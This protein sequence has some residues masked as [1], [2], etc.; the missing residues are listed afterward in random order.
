MPQFQLPRLNRPFLGR[1]PECRRILAA[2][3]RRRLVTLL[4]P[5]GMGKTS[6]AL[7]VAHALR[8]RG[9]PRDGILFVSLRGARSLEAVLFALGRAAGALGSGPRPVLQALRGRRA[10]LVLDN[11]EDPLAVAR[12][13]LQELAAEILRRGKGLRLLLTSSRRLGPVLGGGLVEEVLS[14]GPLPEPA[15]ERLLAR[16][17]GTSPQE[18]ASASASNLIKGLGGHPLAI[19][20]AAPLLARRGPAELASRL[21]DQP[22]DADPRAGTPEPERRAIEA[23]SAAAALAV[24]ELKESRPDAAR[25]LGLLTRLPG[26]ALAEDLDAAAGEGWREPMSALLRSGLV[27]RAELADTGQYTVPLFLLARAARML[28]ESGPM[29]PRAGRHYAAMGRTL[30]RA[31]GAGGKEA[32]AALSLLAVEELNLWAA[33]DPSRGAAG[34]DGL[35]LAACLP[36]ILLRAGRPR[37]ALRAAELGAAALREGSDVHAAERVLQQLVELKLRAG[38]LA[39]A[40]AAGERLVDA[41]RRSGNERTEANALRVL[42]DLKLR[43]KDLGAALRDYELALALHREIGNAAGEANCREGLGRLRLVEENPEAARREFGAALAIHLERG[44][45]QGISANIGYLGRA[46]SAAGRHAAAAVL[47]DEALKLH[48][49]AGDRSGEALDLQSQAEALWALGSRPGALAAWWQA[50]ALFRG[51]HRASAKEIE[52]V[53]AD[54]HARLGEAAYRELLQDLERNAETRRKASVEALRG[55]ALAD[56]FLEGILRSLQP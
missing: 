36:G 10:L 7:A 20:L 31:L 40:R 54:L 44:E 2:L 35:E 4:G 39:S 6:V 28:G 5:A 37:D 45:A 22:V 29:S 18:P 38:D 3:G 41:A 24:A 50:H 25:L 12:D 49:R 42:G 43:Q 26:G 9:R 47:F 52:K 34:D 16:L 8:R 21:R 48:R 27:S 23:L 11:C 14:L 46:E 15:A 19:R 17:S 51:L 1:T 53:F 32:S 56:P 33:L 13:E 30:L 55:A